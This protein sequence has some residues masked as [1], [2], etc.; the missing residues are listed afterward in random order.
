LLP[1][2]PLFA[3]LRK[4]VYQRTFCVWIGRA[5]RPVLGGGVAFLFGLNRGVAIV[6]GV[7]RLFVR[8]FCFSGCRF[9]MRRFSGTNAGGMILIGPPIRGGLARFIGITQPKR[10]RATRD[11]REKETVMRQT[12]VVVR[13]LR[14]RR[15]GQRTARPAF[16]PSFTDA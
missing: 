16:A 7:G 11:Y 2:T 8:R 12:L 13:A 15:V 5:G 14:A 9:A 1:P 6:F 10:E 4:L 3:G